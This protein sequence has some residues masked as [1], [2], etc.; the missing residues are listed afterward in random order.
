[1]RIKTTMTVEFKLDTAFPGFDDDVA[2]SSQALSVAALAADVATAAKFSAAVRV[3]SVT[4]EE[5]H[6]LTPD[7]S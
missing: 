1:M 5:L 7:A 2:R 3:L 6:T 4:H